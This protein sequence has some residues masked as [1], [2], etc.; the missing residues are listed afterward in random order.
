MR[1]ILTVFVFSL[2]LLSAGCAP[3]GNC[4]YCGKTDVEVKTVTFQDSSADLCQECYALFELGLSALE[5]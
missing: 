4:V 2:L 1:L 5:N 3:V